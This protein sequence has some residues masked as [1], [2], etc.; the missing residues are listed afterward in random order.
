LISFVPCADAIPNKDGIYGFCKVRGTFA[1]I[2]EADQ[3]A[4]ELIQKVDSV[5]KILTVKNGSPFP[6]INP[7][8]STKFSESVTKVDVKA[9]AKDE[10]SRFVKM[11]SEEDKKV[12]EELKEREK[13]LRED[14][15]RSPEENEC[16]ILDKYIFA[17]KKVSD[18]LFVFVE[19]RRKLQDMK[20]IIQKAQEEADEIEKSN[21][22]VLDEYKE[23]YA[24]AEKQAGIDKSNDPMAKMIRQNMFEK[25]NLNEIFSNNLV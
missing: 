6:I 23:K 7:K 2:H 1:N 13:Q 24:L 12:M 14:V 18:N 22:E 20:K 8:N 5:H 25:P 11:S 9:C 19:H 4:I 10:I 17:R 15:A 21:P 16:S 3:R